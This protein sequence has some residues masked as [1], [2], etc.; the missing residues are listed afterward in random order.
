MSAE[1]VFG[2]ELQVSTGNQDLEVPTPTDVGNSKK[3]GRRYM[4]GYNL[5]MKENSVSFCL[6]LFYLLYFNTSDLLKAFHFQMYS[7][8]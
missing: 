2:T 8:F 7:W 5:F 4:T 3:R 6:N 1:R